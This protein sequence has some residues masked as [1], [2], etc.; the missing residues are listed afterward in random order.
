MS[1]P[2]KF[3]TGGSACCEAMTGAMRARQIVFLEGC[4]RMITAHSDIEAVPGE[5]EAL[6]VKHC[7]FCGSRVNAHLCAFGIGVP[8]Q[9]C[10]FPSTLPVSTYCGPHT[11]RRNVEHLNR[12]GREARS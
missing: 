12:I 9:S 5:F 2:D 1:G 10:G 4:W 3:N 8:G 11:A 6:P 7:P